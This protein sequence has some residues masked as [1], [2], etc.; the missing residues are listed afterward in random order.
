MKRIVPKILL[1]TAVLMCTQFVNADW[2]KRSVNTLAWL[3]S[4]HFTD[5]KTGWIGGSKGTLLGTTDGGKTWTKKVGVTQ[6]TIRQVIFTDKNNGW[7]LCER[8]IYNLGNSGAS[9]LLK[10]E[11]GGNTWSRTDFKTARRQR[12]TKLFFSKSGFGLAVGETGALFGLEDDNR[13][14]KQL[15]LPSSYLL[16]GGAFVDDLK[17]TIVGGGGTILFTDDAGTTWN[18]AL[19]AGNAPSRFNSVFFNDERT[20]WAV[21]SGGVIAQTVNGGRLWRQQKSSTTEKLND[22]FFLNSAEGWAIGDSGV[23]LHTTTAGNVWR[24]VD[25]KSDHRLESIF[26]RGDHGWVVGFGGTILEYEKVDSGK[27]PRPRFADKR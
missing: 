1:F 18:K 8:D 27:T 12:V 15:P 25:L 5:A 2:H 13:N 22:V 10:T 16:S 17:G 19:V 21:G 23:M 9:Y 7:L 26:F 14:W 6:D 11:N 20:G 24:N 3:H 4:V